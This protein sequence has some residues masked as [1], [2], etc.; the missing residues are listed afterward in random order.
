VESLL[1]N[2]CLKPEYMAISYFCINIIFPLSKLKDL[3]NRR[4]TIS[5]EA[6]I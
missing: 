3:K 2:Y 4:H 5:I 6:E 1:Y